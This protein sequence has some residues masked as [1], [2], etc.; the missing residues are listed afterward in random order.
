MKAGLIKSTFDPLRWKS[1]LRVYL[2]GRGVSPVLSQWALGEFVQECDVLV[3]VVTNIVCKREAP[4]DTLDYKIAALRPRSK[5]IE[6]VRQDIRLGFV[7]ILRE[8]RVS[9]YSL[10][11]FVSRSV[12]EGFRDCNEG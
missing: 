11:Q 10:T 6:D 1:L 4:L 9:N 8:R 5:E 3:D 2:N 12:Q 7:R